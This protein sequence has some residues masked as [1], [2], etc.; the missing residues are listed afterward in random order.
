MLRLIFFTGKEMDQAH[1]H[2]PVFMIGGVSGR[3]TTLGTKIPIA[4][5]M[6][7]NEAFLS[8]HQLNGILELDGSVLDFLKYFVRWLIG[9]IFWMIIILMP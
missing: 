2:N 8:G 4:A 7:G 1:D 3:V 5:D 9:H 6:P